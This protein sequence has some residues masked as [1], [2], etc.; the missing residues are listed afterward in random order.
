MP[1]HAALSSSPAHAANSVVG[2]APRRDC[3]WVWVTCVRVRQ[4]FEGSPRPLPRAFPDQAR[5]RPSRTS[6]AKARASV[7][8]RATVEMRRMVVDVVGCG[9]GR[10]WWRDARQSVSRVRP[11]E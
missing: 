7:E 5:A 4:M 8:A 11:A 2:L 1:A 10:M 3:G 6:A 9:G